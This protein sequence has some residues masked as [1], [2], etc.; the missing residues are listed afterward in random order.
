MA[1]TPE[2]LIAELQQ[3][4]IKHTPDEIIWI[5]RDA[6]GKVVWLENGDQDR[7]AEHILG[8]QKD[9][10]GRKVSKS[11]ILTLVVSA[12]T[13]GRLIGRQGKSR[14]I[15]VVEFGGIEQYISVEI[16]S[17]GYIIGANPSNKKDILRSLK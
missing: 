12:I 14:S 11:E 10:E 9:F 6:Q 3:K 2:D 1:E 4:N 13:D 15:F 16:A 8:K 5:G 17:N 7:G